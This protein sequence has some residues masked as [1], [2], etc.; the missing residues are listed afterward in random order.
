LSAALL[1]TGACFM[2]WRHAVIRQDA[3]HSCD[4]FGCALLIAILLPAS[5][6]AINWR[7]PDR[8]AAIAYAGLFYCIGLMNGAGQPWD[9]RTC[10]PLLKLC[11]LSNWDR[12][13]H[14]VQFKQALGARIGPAPA[15]CQLPRITDRVGSNTIDEMPNEPALVLLNHMN[16]RPRPVFQSY[17]AYT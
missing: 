3:A 14:P 7:T 13:I 5:L 8:I 16:H 17:S 15:T 4:F 10:Q 1:M 9:L 12:L 6:V 2:A 11:Y